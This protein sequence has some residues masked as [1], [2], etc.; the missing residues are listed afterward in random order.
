MNRD[1]LQ[2]FDPLPLTLGERTTRL[3]AEPVNPRA[4]YEAFERGDHGQI[5]LWQQ[6]FDATMRAATSDD[7]GEIIRLAQ[8]RTQSFPVTVER[9][10][11][12]IAKQLG[13]PWPC[14]G[15]VLMQNGKV[16][17]NAKPEPDED[18]G[19][20]DT[21]DLR[22]RFL[23]AR[24]A[25]GDADILSSM[26]SVFIPPFERLDFKSPEA[27]AYVRAL[28]LLVD[29]GK[30]GHAPTSI[31]RLIH[32]AMFVRD[33]KVNHLLNCFGA[34]EWVDIHTKHLAAVYACLRALQ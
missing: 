31:K 17:T 33:E 25:V 11:P 12:E 2:K 23:S 28:E 9:I 32:E 21:P 34:K 29:T 16:F 15:T 13:L 22:S 18:D 24:R 20:G 14:H 7:G 27:V 30:I 26:R 5:D 1:T 3:P 19:E 10:T 8:K 6:R 4:E